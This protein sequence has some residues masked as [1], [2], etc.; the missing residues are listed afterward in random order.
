MTPTNVTDTTGRVRGRPE[1]P[2]PD[3]LT[4]ARTSSPSSPASEAALTVAMWVRAGDLV[5]T[6]TAEDWTHIAAAFEAKP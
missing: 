3:A 6:G 2:G 5:L 4:T 1:V